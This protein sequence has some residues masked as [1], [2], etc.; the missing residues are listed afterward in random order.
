MKVRGKTVS[1]RNP[2]HVIRDAEMVMLFRQGNTLQQIGDRFGITR[3]RVRQCIS[4]MGLCSMD[5]GAALLRLTRTP[6]KVQ[7]AAEQR[8]RNEER[9]FLR[10]GLSLD[11]MAAITR[12]AGVP[13]NNSRHPVRLFRQQRCNATRRGIGWEFT[14]AQWWRV[15]QKSGH[16]H[17]RGRGQGYCMA[18]WAD[19]GPYSVENVYIC[20]IGQ[21]FSDSYIVKPWESRGPGRTRNPGRRRTLG[22]KFWPVKNGVMVQLGDRHR[23]LVADESAARSLLTSHGIAP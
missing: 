10:Y 21:N 9:A 11:E 7:R 2:A 20:T 3:E 15:W 8:Q 5:G 17:E 23:R 19:D 12:E 4:A 16:W 22:R 13:L 1:R 6:D 14:F 18:R